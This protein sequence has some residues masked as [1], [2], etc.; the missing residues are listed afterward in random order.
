MVRGSGK[1][2]AVSPVWCQWHSTTPFS[3]PDT[4]RLQSTG[5]QWTAATAVCTQGKSARQPWLRIEIGGVERGN[6]PLPGKLPSGV[7]LFKLREGNVSHL[8]SSTFPDKKPAGRVPEADAAIAGG[9][10]ADVALAWM[11]AEREARHQVP[12]AHQLP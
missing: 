10:D 2:L 12:V 1:K 9:A 7:C 5:D 11:L 3:S 4:T 6:A 8:V